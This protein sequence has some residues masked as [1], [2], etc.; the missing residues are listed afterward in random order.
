MSNDRQQAAVGEVLE[1]G[2]RGPT[3]PHYVGLFRERAGK[4]TA[5]P[6]NPGSAVAIASS[7]NSLGILIGCRNV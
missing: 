4:R 3:Q 1:R 7:F 6:R 2:A 5:L